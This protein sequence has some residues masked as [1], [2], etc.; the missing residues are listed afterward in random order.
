MNIV[1]PLKFLVAFCAISI[2]LQ[3]FGILDGGIGDS[4]RE[5]LNSI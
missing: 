5:G 1:D 4:F 2:V 3:L